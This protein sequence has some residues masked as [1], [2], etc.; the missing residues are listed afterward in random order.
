[1]LITAAAVAA[2]VWLITPASPATPRGSRVAPES[3]LL[4]RWRAPLSL[5]CA[6]AT[7][8]L[9][10][11]VIGL[12]AAAVAAVAAWRILGRAE[13]AAAQTRQ[14]ELARDLP[15]AVDLLVASLAAGQPPGAALGI[16]VRALDGP[17]ADELA[18]V[19][20]R[21]ESGSDPG[22]VWAELAAHPALGPLGRALGRSHV[23][24]GSVADAGRRLS[25]ELRARRRAEADAR[26]RGVAANAAGP[27][28][29]CF[30]PAFVLLGVVPLIAGLISSLRLFG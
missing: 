25:K 1:M 27:L 3:P 11:G 30:L 19:A 29:L 17:V 22:L 4:R 9:L 24:G 15:D 28:G 13:S 18:P 21:L 8:A 5:A 7:W 14:A 10:G 16:V 23:A 12:V 2:A 26:A 6:A 20:R